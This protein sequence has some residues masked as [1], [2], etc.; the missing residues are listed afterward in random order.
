MI[1]PL[2]EIGMIGGRMQRAWSTAQKGKSGTG[3]FFP[4]QAAKDL[5]TPED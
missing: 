5:E 4:A 1:A 3:V 2:S